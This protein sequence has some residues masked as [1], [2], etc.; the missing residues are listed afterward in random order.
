MRF[1][2][3]LTGQRVPDL[4]DITDGVQHRRTVRFDGRAYVLANAE[5]LTGPLQHSQVKLTFLPAGLVPVGSAKE[6]RS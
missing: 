3:W 4:G 6:D 2:R 5:R 1:W